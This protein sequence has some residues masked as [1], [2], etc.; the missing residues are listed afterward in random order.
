MNLSESL[1]KPRDTKRSCKRSIKIQLSLKESKEFSYYDLYEEIAESK[2]FLEETESMGFTNENSYIYPVFMQSI[3][4]R[5]EKYGQLALQ[6]DI[7]LHSAARKK[8]KIAENDD[9]CVDPSLEYYDL[10]DKFID[11]TEI[12]NDYQES[13]Y[14]YEEAKKEK[15]YVEHDTTKIKAEIVKVSKK[16]KEKKEIS[17]ERD[18]TKDFEN[19]PDDLKEAVIKLKS[20]FYETRRTG[21]KAVFPKGTLF[22]MTQIE[23]LAEIHNIR[24]RTINKILSKIC[25]VK[26]VSIKHAMEK[27]KFK[28]EKNKAKKAYKTQ[29]SAFS[30]LMR[31]ECRKFDFNWNEE[32]RKKLREVLRLL[33]NYV[34]I[35]NE[36]VNNYSKNPKLLNYEDQEKIFIEKLKTQCS[37]KLAGI[38]LKE[39][40]RVHAE[41]KKNEPK[42]PILS[43]FFDKMPDF[44]ISDFYYEPINQLT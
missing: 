36:F 17:Y 40:I 28:T 7:G 1:D 29:R 13:D 12:L 6:D 37:P 20:V 11:D 8:M 43:R 22:I 39:R 3:I 34:K 10:D 21:A 19:L 16:S 24:I 9:S 15:F 18:E 30:S 5:L 32:L 2:G 23:K 26:Y 42:L 44:N 41:V 31:S 35:S 14:L 27:I 33:S 38:N 25:K 4:E